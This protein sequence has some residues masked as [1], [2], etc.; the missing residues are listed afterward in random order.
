MVAK[1]NPGTIYYLK[2]SIGASADKK[3]GYFANRA[4]GTVDISSYTTISLWVDGN[5]YEGGYQEITFS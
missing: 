3:T 1:P 5:L 2:D 4:G